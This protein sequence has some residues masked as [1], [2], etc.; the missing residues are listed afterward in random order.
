M[1]AGYTLGPGTWTLCDA[2]FE[3]ITDGRG[4]LTAGDRAVAFLRPEHQLSAYLRVKEVC[5]GLGGISLGA[6]RAGCCSLAHLDCSPLAVEALRLN[7]STVV[8]GFLQDRGSCQALAAGVPCQ[9]YSVLGLGLGLSDGR[10]QTLF[11]VF[12]AAW[13]LQSSGLILECVT[14][15]QRHDDMMQALAGFA[16]RMGWQQSQVCLELGE[17]WGSR[18]HRWWCVMLLACPAFELLPWRRGPQYSSVQAIIPRWPLWSREE[19]T[20]LTWTEEEREKYG[21]PAY[22]SDAR[23]LCVTALA[24]TALHSWGVA[25]RPCPCGCRSAAFSDKRLRSG[26]LRGFGV[27]SQLTGRSDSLMRKKSAYSMHCHLPMSMFKILGPPS[28]L[29][30]SWLPPCNPHGG[31]AMLF[32]GQSFTFSATLPAAP[33][34]SCRE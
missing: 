32:H 11:A 22:G 3:G 34:P 13:L 8:Q 15:I 21:D 7:G 33:L 24:P 31:S 29:L 25:L 2:I 30:D 5:A 20:A 27:V 26:G 12:R 16:A 23:R 19:E 9:P 14:E 1:V 28:A 4:Q 18:R 17:Q 6:E 10:G